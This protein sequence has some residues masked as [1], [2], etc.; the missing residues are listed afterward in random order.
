MDMNQQL[1]MQ[2]M[3]MNQQLHM[4][5][6]QMQE[7]NRQLQ[8]FANFSMEAK[9][10]QEILKSIEE[11]IKTGVVIKGVKCLELGDLE[12]Y[13]AV[14]RDILN[15]EYVTVSKEDMKE[16]FRV[17]AIM[18]QVI[19]G[20]KVN[21]GGAPFNE[22][23][24]ILKHIKNME[25]E[26]IKIMKL[27]HAGVHAGRANLLTNNAVKKL[28]GFNINDVNLIRQ[29]ISWCVEIVEARENVREEGAGTRTNLFG[30]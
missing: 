6:M 29:Q 13:M 18:T 17:L 1:H 10:D 23:L 7:N 27:E 14:S 8:Q 9:P 28:G 26:T 5:D 3:E 22:T 16:L 21:K 4:Q 15:R 24:Y 20:K 19:Q 12:K 25:D 30:E 11:S 2:D